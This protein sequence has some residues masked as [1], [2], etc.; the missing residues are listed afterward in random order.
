MRTWISS[1]QHTDIYPSQ[2]VTPHDG[3]WTPRRLND[4]EFCS[5]SCIRRTCSMCVQFCAANMQTLLI[6]QQSLELGRPPSIALAYVDCALPLAQ[7]DNDADDQCMFGLCSD[8]FILLMAQA[9]WNWKY[10]FNRDFSES[11][12]QLT[13]SAKPPEY[14]TV[15]D[16]DRKI[17]EAPMPAALNS[18]ANDHDYSHVG[19]GLYMKGGY[20][21]MV[22][23]V[24]M[25]YIH[26][27]FFARAL[28]DHPANPLNSPYATSFLAT[29]RC[30]S[31]II[32]TNSIHISRY[33]DFCMRYG[34]V[35]LVPSI[36][37]HY[38][39]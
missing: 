2:I 22:R 39:H 31:S 38:F 32:R 21:T 17:R 35:V 37:S 28:L 26:R 4:G 19:L 23:S 30:A 9:V 29:A 6:T 20:L 11:L 7:S 3:I 27:N 18:L 12:I 8:Q 10:Q 34:Y 36:G 15:L 5:G 16:F 13:L 24:A 1:C 33:P 25:L 14:R